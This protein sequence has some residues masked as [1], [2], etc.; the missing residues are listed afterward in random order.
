MKRTINRVARAAAFTVATLT[1]AWLTAAPVYAAPP[2]EPDPTAHLNR[3]LDNATT[4]L[5]GILAGVATLFLT[6]G[7]VR[8]VMA[9]GDPGEV[10]K[11]KGSFKAAGLGYALA[12]LAPIIV[13]VIKGILG[14][15]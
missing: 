8:Y 2:A 7:G 10:G 9:G 13:A 15:A 14:I 12:A 1:V 6:V 11:A 3:I 4:W 5:V